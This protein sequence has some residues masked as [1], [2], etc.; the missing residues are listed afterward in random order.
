MNKK[1]TLAPILVFLIG[2][3]IFLYPFIANKIALY[4]QSK[5]I[6]TYKADMDSV[7]IQ[8]LEQEKQ[9]AEIYNDN[10]SGD[11]VHDPFVLNSGYVLPDNYL[12]VLDISGDGVMC[13]I[14]IPEISVNLPVYHGTGEEE[15]EKGVGHLEGTA[16][17]IGGTYRHSILCAHRG[18]P[19][20]ELFSRLNELEEGDLF[21]INV[22]GEIH[23]YAIDQIETV[24]PEDINKYLSPE[25]DRDMITLMTCTPYGINTHRLL[26]RGSRTG[27][28][29]EEKE[30]I[31]DKKSETTRLIAI[32]AGVLLLCSILIFTVLRYAKKKKRK[33]KARKRKRRRTK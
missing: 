13:Y 9:E 12:N 33:R 1:I 28:V 3:A 30:E 19:S 4:Q 10:L 8:E 21:Y 26:V 16:L 25:E 14:E 22:L 15:L 29:P 23:A 24:L 2:A 32:C 7:T 6:R 17:P 27:Y 5:E 31:H 11:P 20:A 18:L